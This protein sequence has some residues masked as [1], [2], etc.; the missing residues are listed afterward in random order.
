MEGI[1]S[2]IKPQD[3]MG[4]LIFT[5]MYAIASDFLSI[6]QPTDIPQFKWKSLPTYFTS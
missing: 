2:V 4:L 5:F 1:P 3:K 6:R